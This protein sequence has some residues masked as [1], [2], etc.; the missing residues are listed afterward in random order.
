MAAPAP[1]HTASSKSAEVYFHF[2]IDCIRVP[3]CFT[4]QVGLR[5]MG[6][7]PAGVV[8]PM[9]GHHHLLVD[10]NKIDLNQPIPSNYNPIHLGNG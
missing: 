7:A 3:Q 2:P 9:T 6:I 10:V 8:R 4:V 1:E 5:G